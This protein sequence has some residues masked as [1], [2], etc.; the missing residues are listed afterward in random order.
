MRHQGQMKGG[1][2]GM[3]TKGPCPLCGEEMYRNLD[4]HHLVPKARGGKKK[5]KLHKVCHRKIHSAFSNKQLE[6]ELNTWEKLKEQQEI[7]TYVE[8]VKKKFKADP[9]FITSFRQK[10]S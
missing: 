3:E 6:R 7:I 5:H 8:W 9:N 1:E 4:F 2:P 10:K